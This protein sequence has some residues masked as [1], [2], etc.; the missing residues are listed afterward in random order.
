MKQFDSYIIYGC[1]FPENIYNM[2]MKNTSLSFFNS[3]ISFQFNCKI[4]ELDIPIYEKTEQKIYFLGIILEQS[5]ASILQYDNIK[6]IDKTGYYK[7]LE[8]FDID[9]KDPY[10][11]SV[12]IVRNL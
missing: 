1:H 5:D 7:M 10:L 6:N 3:K 11:I 12:P 4:Y 2:I 8:T 9:N